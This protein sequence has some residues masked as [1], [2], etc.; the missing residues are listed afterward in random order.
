LPIDPIAAGSGSSLYA[1]APTRAPQQTMDGELFMQL[2]T[3]QLKNQDPSAPMDTNAMIAQTTQLSMMEKLNTMASTGTD[4][5]NLQMRASAAA[6]LGATV[7][8][9][10]ADGS[11]VTGE[12]TSVNY[13]P[14]KP[15]LVT[16]GGDTVSLDDL[17]TVT[18]S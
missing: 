15:P 6:L 14:G 18:S 8:Y 17:T 10:G 11:T 4:S 3:T 16:V 13:T 7:S 9:T 12:A 1:P 2:L 5:F